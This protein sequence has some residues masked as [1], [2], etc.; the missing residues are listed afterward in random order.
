MLY[1]VARVTASGVI[2]N[3]VNVTSTENDTNES[4]N[5]GKSDDVTALPVVD[6]EITKLV[7]V[8]T[9]VVNVSDLI[10]FTI[11]CYK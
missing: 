1:I 4:N 10:K 9:G 6:L 11:K 5:K 7:N 3:T 8:T 2:P